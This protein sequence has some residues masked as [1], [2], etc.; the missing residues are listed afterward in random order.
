MGAQAMA[1][2][3]YPFS[4]LSSLA[5]GLRAARLWWGLLR[6]RDDYQ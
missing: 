4:T 5:P 2:R 1:K 6:N 3:N